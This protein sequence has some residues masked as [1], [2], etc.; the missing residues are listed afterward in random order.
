VTTFSGSQSRATKAPRSKAITYPH[1]VRKG[2]V[3][4]TIYRINNP[5]RGEVFEVTWFKAGQRNRKTFR[6]AQEALDHAGETVKAL[7]SGK[8]DS[9]ALSGAELEG[10]RLAK[11]TLSSLDNPPP[12]HSA[13][14]EFVAARQLLGNKPIL[15]ALEKYL[16]DAS[17]QLLKPIAIPALVEEFISGKEADGVSERYLQDCRSRLRKFAKSFQT[18][19]ATVKTGDIDTWLRALRHSPRSRNNY[20]VLLVTMF[21]F[22]RSCGYLPRDR[23]TEADHV[24]LAK[25]VG[26]PIEIYSLTE[27]QK[28]LNH[29]D[30]HTLPFVALA[31]FAGLRSAEIERLTWDCVKWDQN[32]IEV[33]AQMAKTSQRRLVP[34]P[35]NLTKALSKWRNATGPVVGHVKIFMRLEWLADASG[36]KWKRNALRHSYASYRLAIIQDAGKLAL[37]MGNSPSMVFRHYRELVTEPDAEKWF[38]LRPKKK[39]LEKKKGARKRK[40]ATKVAPDGQP[41]HA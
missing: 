14:Q 11:R 24:A 21:R 28:L 6:D 10:F 16:A 12:L 35:S 31:G 22:A 41:P 20:R 23:S 32:L 18:Q 33:R 30:D 36:V 8:G 17:T 39:L 37:E 9:L 40:L 29:A 15:P 5:A 26:N 27:M 13:I 25:D 19:I 7:D 3:Q 38:A 1:V 2:S 4:V 34:M